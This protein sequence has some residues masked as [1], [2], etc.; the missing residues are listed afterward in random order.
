MGP[1]QYVRLASWDA[2]RLSSAFPHH[3]PSRTVRCFS[4]WGK[5]LL[6]ARKPRSRGD[7]RGVT[8]LQEDPRPQQATQE[9]ESH[10]DLKSHP[11]LKTDADGT[12]VKKFWPQFRKQNAPP[13]NEEFVNLRNDDF[14]RKKSR[15]QQ[16]PLSVE[17]TEGSEILFG[18]A[19]CSLAL[20]RSKRNFFQ[21]FLKVS[22]GDASPAMMDFSQQAQDR[23]IP[24]KWVSRKV[25]NALCKG[26]V[27]QGVCLEATPLQPVGWQEGTPLQSEGATVSEGSQLLWLVLERILDP[28]NL[29]AILRSAHFL[30]VDRIV[31]SQKNSCPL[32]PVVSKA[33]SGAMEVL[34][35]F[36]TDD[37]QS[38]LKTKSDQGWEIL[39]TI[40]AKRPPDDIPIVSCLDFRW[41]SPTV[42]MLGNEGSGLSPE[43]RSL[44]HRM[45][46]IP[47]GRELEAGIECLNVSV[48]AGILLHSIC[49]QKM[50]AP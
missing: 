21:L 10:S 24:T 28:M 42:L 27:H 38:F 8:S 37:L 39:G 35:V 30:G 4:G 36:A 45:L 33:S 19:P 13:S 49:R 43:I 9:E 22:K 25:L 29:G 26:G 20:Q 3:R 14:P 2:L 23:G 17:R 12:P 16:I 48:A 34:D 40:G 7:G 41:T 11:V 44:C 46:T 32:T 47:P 18:F 31:M 15:I 50:K 1:L 5:P 6:V